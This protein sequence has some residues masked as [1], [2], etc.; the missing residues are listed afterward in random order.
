MTPDAIA[1]DPYS[2]LVD[3]WDQ[4]SEHMG[5]DDVRFYAEESARVSGPVVELGVG[6]GRVAIPV[7]KAGQ[8]VIGVDVSEAMVTDGKRR[9]AQ[10]GVG[11][12]ITWVV[13]DMRSFVADPR[14]SL[15]TIPFR[16]FLHLRTV[17]DQLAALGAVNR[18]LMPG[19]R[20]ILNVFVPDPSVMVALDG[21]R[22]LQADFVD[23]RGRRCEI[24]AISSYRLADQGLKLRVILEV[25][26]AG[27]LADTVEAEMELHL[28][29]PFEMR[30]LLERAG[31]EVESVYGW[32]D[33]RPFD[34][35]S[36]EMIWVARKP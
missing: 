26:D 22:K 3:V 1:F 7:A 33:R 34:E 14:V 35:G 27:R 9:A 11:E 6:S 8:R 28:V 5:T 23:E 17:A 13:G 12:R 29:Y 15:V 16:S 19:G 25:Y 31:F 10:A 4:W 18:S 21:Q 24:W 30:H 36:R 32:F 2:I 20:L